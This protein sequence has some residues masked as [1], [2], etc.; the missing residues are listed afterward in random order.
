MN[1]LQLT[2]AQIDFYHR[3]G[4]LTLPAL[5]T[6]EELQEI[7]AIYD[8]LFAE[9]VGRD[10]GNQFDLAGTDEDDAG[11]HTA[12]DPGSSSLCP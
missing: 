9:R 11:G 12:A 6:P 3:E 7:G 5:T 1:S 2:Q 10:E 4:Y 8:R